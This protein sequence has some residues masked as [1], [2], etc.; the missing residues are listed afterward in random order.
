MRAIVLMGFM[1]TG[2]SEVGRRLAQRLGRIF[3]DTDAMIVE[4]AG[5][6][7]PAIFAEDG[8]V[9]FRTLEAEAVAEAVRRHGAVIAVGGGAVVDP[10]NAGRL[11]AA[12]V[13]VHLTADPETILAR[14]GDAPDRPLLAGGDP[15][16]AVTRLLAEREAAYTAAAD[17]TVD[18]SARTVDEVVD[19]IRRTVA[20]QGPGNR[21]R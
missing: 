9:R 13:M 10:A 21:W 7:V 4:R 8:E 11:R 6:S 3:V 5:K 14:V 20:G 16:E 17:V 18:T 2:K 15:R 19:E 1:G 12:G